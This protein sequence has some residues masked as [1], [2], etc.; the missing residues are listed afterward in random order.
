MSYT[1]TGGRSTM[2]WSACN[3]QQTS[4]LYRALRFHHPLLL[5]D[6]WD[7]GPHIRLAGLCTCTWVLHTVCVCVFVFVFAVSVC[8][9][10]GH[11][12]LLFKL[13]EIIVTI[14]TTPLCV[15]PCTG[16]LCLHQRWLH[17]GTVRFP[18]RADLEHCGDRTWQYCPVLRCHYHGS[19]GSNFHEAAGG[20]MTKRLNT[21]IHYTDIIGVGGELCELEPPIIG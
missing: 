10:G 8:G 19:Q 1:Y 7:S 20:T 16:W 3:Q 21:N 11:L 6:I 4:K 5:L 12:V 18:F 17:G 2:C 9:R 15:C 14:K 13:L